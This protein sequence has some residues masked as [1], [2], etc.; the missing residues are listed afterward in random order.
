MPGLGWS[1]CGSLGLRDGGLEREDAAAFEQD[2]GGFGQRVSQFHFSAQV[3]AE[4][5]GEL[6]EFE[7]EGVAGFGFGGGAA[8]EG[9]PD[10]DDEF[11]GDSGDGDVAVAFADEKTPTPFAKRAV[12]AFVHDALGSL[13]EELAQVAT[14]AF[15]DAQA[16]VLVFTALAL[17]GVEIG[18]AHV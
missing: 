3:F 18:R 10:L 12:T 4:C 1:W 16:D 8:L 17:A 13:D 11:S 9:V 6:L 5:E 14:A 15:A 2:G 7:A